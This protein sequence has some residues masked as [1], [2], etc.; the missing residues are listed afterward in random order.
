VLVERLKVYALSTNPS[1]AKTNNNKKTH[2]FF[3]IVF[4]KFGNSD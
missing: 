4:S 1:T 3:P 2:L